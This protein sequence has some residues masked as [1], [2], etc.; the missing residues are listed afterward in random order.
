MWLEI[1]VL[2]IPLVM[3]FVQAFVKQ[4]AMADRTENV[5][6]W[7]EYKNRRVSS[8]NSIF[9]RI[10]QYSVHLLYSLFRTIHDLTAGIADR[11]IRSGIRL[12]AYLYLLV[13]LF[14]LLI[15]FG[16]KIILLAVAGLGLFLVL[17][18]LMR[19]LSAHKSFR[20]GDPSG[21]FV[22]NFWPF[23]RS[24]S[25]KSQVAVLF[26]VNRIDVDYTGDILSPG[27]G[28]SSGKKRIGRVDKKGRIYD[29]RKRAAE[30]IGWI[31]A[32]GRVIGDRLINRSS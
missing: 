27:S 29:T 30:Q 21:G 6:A 28:P 8:G 4:D 7:L 26:E 20:S 32:H 12:A 10:A 15:T 11:G 13:F 19:R 17:I 31:D 23:F 22:E 16:Y 2:L 14:I 9:A 5:V 1:I 24:D 18:M 25:T 3:G